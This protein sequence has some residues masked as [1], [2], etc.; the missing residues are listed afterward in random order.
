MMNWYERMSWLLRIEHDGTELMR[1]SL[2][3][4]FEREYRLE[5]CPILPGSTCRDEAT[6]SDQFEK[7]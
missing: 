6:K 2:D 5:S 1:R 7:L 3:S 4:W